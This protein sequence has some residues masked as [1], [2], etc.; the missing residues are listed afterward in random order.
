[1]ALCEAPS[2][3]IE[4]DRRAGRPGSA[5]QVTRWLVQVACEME[6]ARRETRAVEVPFG[7]GRWVRARQDA[8]PGFGQSERR[9]L[10]LKAK[11]SKFQAEHVQAFG[12]GSGISSPH[13]EDDVDEV[14]ASGS[15]VDRPSAAGARL[16]DP[17]PLDI[18]ELAALRCQ[19]LS[20]ANLA[21]PHRQEAHRLGPRQGPRSQRDRI[22][23][24]QGEHRGCPAWL[25]LGRP[26]P[27]QRDQRESPV[28]LDDA[29][30]DAVLGALAGKQGGTPGRAHRRRRH[31]AGSRALRPCAGRVRRPWR[32][33][34]QWRRIRRADIAVADGQG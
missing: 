5:V 12:E 2:E 4:N 15:G 16:K 1:M 33:T 31:A 26:S 7:D 18:R 10:G 25:D 28:A 32:P 13:E 30:T 6:K 20:R 24:G 19:P 22:D 23:A 14:E 9:D 34:P 17:L 11:G 21:E 29:R 8:A 3:A 27:T